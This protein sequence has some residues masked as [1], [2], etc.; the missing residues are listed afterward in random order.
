L[1]FSQ[2]KTWPQEFTVLP[3]KRSVSPFLESRLTFYFD[4]NRN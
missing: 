3:I 2:Q 1:G 4:Y